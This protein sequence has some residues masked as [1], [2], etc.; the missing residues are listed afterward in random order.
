MGFST[1]HVTALDEQNMLNAPLN[2][3]LTAQFFCSHVSANIIVLTSPWSD[4]S[5]EQNRLLIVSIPLLQR[6]S[7]TSRST[8]ILANTRTRHGMDIYAL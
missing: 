2:F 4:S 5:S 7:S 6:C 3:S 1:L 8:T